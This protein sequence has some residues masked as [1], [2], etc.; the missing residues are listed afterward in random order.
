MRSFARLAVAGLISFAS[1][2]AS[3]LTAHADQPATYV[4]IRGDSLS[5]IASKMG[6]RLSALLSTNGLKITSVILPGQELMVPAGGSLPAPSPSTSSATNT[7]S[8][9]G[10]YTIK[11][12]DSLSAI[13]GR[14]KVS[15]NALLAAN[16][17]TVTSLILPGQ[18]INLPAGAT[19]AQ[20]V[21]S[22]TS[23][24]SASNNSGTNTSSST[25]LTYTIKKGDSLSVIASRHKVTLSALLAANNM[26]VTSLILPGMTINLPAGATASGAG[27]TATSGTGSSGSTST[28]NNASL[29]A[30]LA[31]ALAQVGK[32]YQFLGKGPDV[33]DCSGLVKSAYAQ[34]GVQLI[35][36]SASQ[37]KQGTPVDFINEPILPGDLIFL[38]THGSTVINHVGMA[39]DATRWVHA[40]RPGDF[41]RTG[42]IPSK[43]NI[44]A[45]RRFIPAS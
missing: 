9:P 7:T 5:G 15:L 43:S 22:A 6:V 29:D 10:T 30:V 2:A 31:Y 13:A 14:Y 25:G 3:D 45:V 1:L 42:S 39:I 8:A 37:A 23:G 16:N 11:N 34:A 35:H 36:Q 27:T 28:T 26:T 44:V 17:M 32:P 41:V 4:V 12:G 40:V 18:T 20:A 33:F 21:P 19:A 38:A 24:N